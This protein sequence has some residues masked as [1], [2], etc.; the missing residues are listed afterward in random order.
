M[1]SPFMDRHIGKEPQVSYEQD[2]ENPQQ[3]LSGVDKSSLQGLREIE[4]GCSHRITPD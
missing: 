4:M 1:T 3:P 2:D